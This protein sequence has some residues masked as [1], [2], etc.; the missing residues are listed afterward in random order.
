VLVLAV[1]CGGPKVEF[2]LIKIHAVNLYFFHSISARHL[3]R[4][5][6]QIRSVLYP[7]E[8][9]RERMVNQ[10]YLLSYTMTRFVQLSRKLSTRGLAPFASTYYV[11]AGARLGSTF[12][13]AQ[14]L[15]QER[16]I[17]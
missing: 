7:V 11:D 5:D 8:N 12:M 15:L 6:R 17:S 4:N 13:H 9:R 10:L 2:R 3:V 16:L 1:V 14:P